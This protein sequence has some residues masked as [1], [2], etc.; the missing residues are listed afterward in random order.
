MP[1]VWK[2]LNESTTG[3]SDKRPASGHP[4]DK[5]DKGSLAGSE[6]TCAFWMRNEGMG[7][8][9][10]PGGGEVGEGRVGGREDTRA[11]GGRGS[12]SNTEQKPSLLSLDLIH[13]TGENLHWKTCVYE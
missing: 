7:E 2:A 3:L 5:R 11:A 12:S 13:E 4:G 10:R 6:R 8:T 1:R 9:V